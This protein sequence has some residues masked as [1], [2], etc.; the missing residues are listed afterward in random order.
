[1]LNSGEVGIGVTTPNQRLDVNGNVNST[2]YRVGNNVV[3][4]APITSGTAGT[5]GQVLTSAGST[6]SPTWTT[7]TKA[8]VGLGNVDN[9]SDADKTISTAT[10]TALN[11]KA[12]TL[13]T[14]AIAD[15]TG[16]QG[17]LDSKANSSHTHAIAD[18]TGLQSALDAKENSI[19]SG[20]TSQ[21]WRGD[22]TWQTLNKAA[23]GLSNVDNTSDA[24][25]PVSSA[26]Q[27]ALNAKQDT[28]V[29][30]TNIRTINGVGILG[31]GDITVSSSQWVTSG[32]NISYSGGNVGIGTSSPTGELHI[33]GAN[34]AFR[35]QGNTSG[36]MQF[37]QWDG[38]TNRIQASGRDFSLITTDATNMLFSTNNTERMRI[39]S[40]GNVGI[41][42]TTPDSTLTV[43]GTNSS[44][45]RL[46]SADTN[47]GFIYVDSGE[48]AFGS[49]TDLPINLQTNGGTRL[50]IRPNGNVGI[51]TSSP[52]IP[53]GRG[54]HIQGVDEIAYFRLSVAGMTGYDVYKAGFDGY[55]FNRDNGHIIIGTNNTERIRVNNT[56]NVGIGTTAP[57]ERLHVSGNILA[58]GNISS[59]SDA[60][61]KENIRSIDNPLEKVLKIEG[62]VYDRIDSEEKDNIGFIAQDFEQI[63]PE[64]VRTD[65]EG[66]KSINYQNMV[67]VLVEAMKEQQK[68]I[69][70]LKN[71]L[72]A[73]T[74]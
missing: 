34:P 7:L 66:Y 27:T 41:G 35:I 71:R 36:N 29:S 49:N 58:N 43:N 42:T 68:E 39:T 21:Y 57:S 50:S 64:L 1:M 48:I 54:M 72:D 38:S 14:H 25:K 5:S 8:S 22:K 47:R 11:G 23:V 18:V 63:I 73:F 4:T 2:G 45:I 28:L 9:T 17:D 32:S 33:A 62:V 61:F 56:G 55:L 52:S 51:G 60:R 20:T 31:S 30:G 13:H 53:V 46:R 26:T 67:A 40:G 24:D 37:G 70:E 6:S 3:F 12:N 16:L 44:Q 15:V 74:K 69:V 19:A 65:D 59:T 10:Q